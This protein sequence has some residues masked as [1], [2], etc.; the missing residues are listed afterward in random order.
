MLPREH[1]HALFHPSFLRVLL[2]RC[3]AVLPYFAHP[4]AW[5]SQKGKALPN[6]GGIVVRLR[7]KW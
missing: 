7:L 4:V 2:A 1:G 6:N 5:L 3:Q